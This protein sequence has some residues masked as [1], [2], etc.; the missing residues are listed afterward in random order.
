MKQTSRNIL[1]LFTSDVVRRVLGFFSLAYLART[2]GMEEFG[3]VAISWTVLSYASVL[4]SAGLH[5]M[6]VRTVAQKSQEFGVGE[7]VLT[8]FVNALAVLFVTACIIV[9]ALPLVRF[10]WL[11]LLTSCS[12]VLHALFLEWYFQGREEMMV[13]GA[14]RI[15]SALVYLLILLLWVKSSADIM[16]TGIAALVGDASLAALL[17][18][19]YIAGGSRTSFTPLEAERPAPIHRGGD[20]RPSQPKRLLRRSRQCSLVLANIKFN[21]PLAPLDNLSNGVNELLT[22]FTLSARRWKAILQSSLPL[23]IGGIIAFVSTNF[24]IMAVGLIL[25]TKEAGVFSAGFRLVSFLLM[26]DR[27]LGSVL[28]PASSRLQSANPAVLS[29]TLSRTLRWM[30]IA[31]L[32]LCVGGGMLAEEILVFVFGPAYLASAAVFQIVLWYFLATMIHTVFVSAMIATGREKE[33]AH[34]MVISGLIYGFTIIGLILAV[35]VVGGA[36]ALVLSEAATVWMMHRAVR[37]T[38]VIHLPKHTLGLL[39]AVGA[40]AAVLFFAPP[41]HVMAKI[42]LGGLIFLITLV[43]SKGISL[44]DLRELRSQF[45]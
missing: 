18:W 32:P 15:A 8:R 26:I 19:K 14:G 38:V 13:I 30:F 24:P 16:V 44:G 23:G 29:E 1:S 33:F 43:V 37:S 9:V 34:I 39:M 45:V 12:V 21:A 31:G 27:V 11:I 42:A 10:G 20:A 6:G 36:M 3:A 5:V 28:L 4:S 7:M 2:I 17:W 22:G 35:G 25:S 40:M 41:L